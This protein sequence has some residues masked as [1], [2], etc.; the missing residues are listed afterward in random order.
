MVQPRQSGSTAAIRAQRK[1]S[2]AQ[3]ESVLEQPERRRDA[4]SNHERILD[5]ARSELAR[6]P[7][8]SLSEIAQAAGVVR[9]TVYGHFP[10]RRALVS[11]LAAEGREALA[12]A[13]RGA[14]RD[15]GEAPEALARMVLA[16]WSV[17]DRYRMLIALGRRDLGED[18]F[19]A[20]LAPARGEASAV[21]ER[22][23]REGSI[24]DHLPAAVLS[25]AT[26]AVTL[27]LV[28]DAVA[29]PEYGLTGEIAATAV[30][31]S[32]GVGLGPARA[33]VRA[34]AAD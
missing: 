13:V 23:Q 16:S 18:A 34:A 8:A 19:T 2:A 9:R 33:Y 6:N 22:G 24:A 28:E 29:H 26:E 7:D 21:I 20:A 15:G 5:A 3:P 17:A 4:R 1:S 11:A 30:L 10:N 32:A 12:G 25:R 31:V 27:A 14:R